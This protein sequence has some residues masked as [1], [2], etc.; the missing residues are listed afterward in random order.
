MCGRPEKCW[1]SERQLEQAGVAKMG[2]GSHS[3]SHSTKMGRG[4]HSGLLSSAYQS[5]HLAGFQQG[6]ALVCLPSAYQS[7]RNHLATFGWNWTNKNVSLIGACLFS[8][9]AVLLLGLCHC[10]Y[11]AFLYM[12]HFHL[13]MPLYIHH[14]SICRSFPSCCAPVY[15][16][17]SVY[18]GIFIALRAPHTHP[19]VYMQGHS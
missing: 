6:S 5:R 2:R 8:A 16:P 12:G 10:V 13:I 17:H 14:L 7:C 9:P 4:S 1:L 3:G 15:T 11:T 18:L 19:G